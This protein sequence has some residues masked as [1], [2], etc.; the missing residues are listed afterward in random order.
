M[1]VVAVLVVALVLLTVIDIPSLGVLSEPHFF[2][3]L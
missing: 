2:R 1:T 3:L